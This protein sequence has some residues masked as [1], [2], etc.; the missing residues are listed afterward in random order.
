MRARHAPSIG[1]KTMISRIVYSTAGL[2]LIAAL[3]AGVA[4]KSVR[5]SSGRSDE[6]RPVRL[7]VSAMGGPIG[8]IAPGST[9]R[10]SVAING[11]ELSGEQ[12]IWGGELLQ[13]PQGGSVSL[14]FDSIG[15]VTLGG[16]AVARFAA[17]PSGEAARRVL[18]A[19]LIAGDIAL[20][21]NGDASAYVEAAG[22]SFT[23]SAGASFRLGVREGQPVLSA[24]SG[25][26]DEQQPAAQR[27]YV[28]RPV[29]SGSTI[30]VRTRSTR[31]LQIQV[32]DENDR[33]VPDL[34]ILFLLAGAGGQNAGTLGAGAAASTS[35]TV[36]TNA[37]GIATITYTAP[38]QAGQES[39]T[40]T[41]QGTR[42][43]HTW[44]VTIAAA[45][46]GFWSARNSLILAGIAGGATAAIV[47]A[48]TGGDEEEI[49]PLPPPQVRP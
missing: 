31:Q 39:I 9:A 41:V 19:S 14:S 11:R 43:S 10:G 5:A 34:P 6:E 2:F 20:K 23:A 47:V 48:S 4:P 28:L 22:S 36:T 13:A 46:A 25:I 45:G 35:A 18:I 44:Q 38:S 33:S 24:V 15:R 40:A 26:V 37:Q 1:E 16:G 30:S 12:M 32:T 27:Q 7:F 21:L 42:Y 29:G 3:A 49:R 17:R 8:V